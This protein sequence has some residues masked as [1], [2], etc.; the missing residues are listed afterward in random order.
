MAYSF[1]RPQLVKINCKDVW[2]PR[3]GRRTLADLTR[4]DSAVVWASIN[5]K[6]ASAIYD[7]K[8]TFKD[9]YV[10]MWEPKYAPAIDEI[11]KFTSEY[12]QAFLFMMDRIGKM[13]TLMTTPNHRGVSKL[14]GYDDALNQ[15]HIHAKL[16]VELNMDSIHIKVVKNDDGTIFVEFAWSAAAVACFEAE[17][18]TPKHID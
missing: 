1:P 10:M 9:D 13:N 4:E 6:L 18:I 17:R 14:T 16:V 15:L 3:C 8:I 11:V 12:R 2:N 7:A 5:L